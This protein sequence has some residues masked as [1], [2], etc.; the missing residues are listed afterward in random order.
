[1]CNFLKSKKVEIKLFFLLYPIVFTA[2]VISIRYGTNR[3]VS[4][5]VQWSEIFSRLPL[6]LL[7]TFVVVFIFIYSFPELKKI[8]KSE[9]GEK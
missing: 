6:L 4:H 9:N 8:F 5:S 3:S 2:G 1:M 7:I